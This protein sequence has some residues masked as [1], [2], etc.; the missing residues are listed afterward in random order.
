MK[1]GRRNES[2]NDLKNQ[3]RLKMGA[4]TKVKNLPPEMEKIF[5]LEKMV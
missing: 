5:F 1:A 2:I 4:K 3:K